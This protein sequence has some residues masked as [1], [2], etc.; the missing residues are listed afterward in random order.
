MAKQI[1]K[2][3][4]N[5]KGQK[6]NNAPR[7]NNQAQVD[8]I[9]YSD[10][11][12]VAELAAKCNK[13]A[14]DIIKILFMLS[15][16]VT[17]NSPLDEETVELVCLEFGIEATKVEPKEENSLEDDEIDD[18]TDLEERPP[19]VT[20]M[21][22]VDHGKTTLLDSIRSTKVVDGE[23]G[24]I[25]Q[26]IGAYQVEVGGKKITFLDT[27]GHEAFTAMRAR[28]AKVTDVSII[29]VA[30]DDGVMP[31]T[32]EAVDHSK[33]AD[34]PIIVAVNKMDKPEANPDRVKNEMADLGLIPEDWG[35]ETIFVN[36]S[37]KKGDGIQDILETILVVSEVKELKANPHKLATGTVI[38]AKLDKG[39]GPV[40]TVLVQNGTLRQGDSIVV[41]SVGAGSTRA[42]ILSRDL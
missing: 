14:S 42:M 9:T 22:H 34:V 21:G 37:A 31:Q 20:I 35:G 33:V 26:H 16:M 17:I 11:I 2:K 36:C 1:K 32:R 10:G 27:P 30:A 40:T 23:F 39:R 8:A 13:S 41:G 5:K 12:T 29:V 7:T 3:P 24:G 15:K 18:P 4:I 28:G 19:I 38:E 25:T 6:P